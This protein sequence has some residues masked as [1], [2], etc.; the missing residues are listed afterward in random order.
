VE[1]PQLSTTVPGPNNVVPSVKALQALLVGKWGISC[2]PS[3]IDGRYGPGTEDAVK[4]MQSQANGASGP[5]D[6][7]CGLTTWTYAVNG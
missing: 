2:G 7:I 1:T 3:G 6:G 4:A 5:V